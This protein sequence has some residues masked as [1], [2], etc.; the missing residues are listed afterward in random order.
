MHTHAPQDLSLAQASQVKLGKIPGICLPSK[1]KR[2]KKKERVLSLDELSAGHVCAEPLVVSDR[3]SS[4]V[5][6]E[7][8]LMS[9]PCERR[10]N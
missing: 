6:L 10:E 9:N 1:T 7:S 3:L 4:H 8:R 5:F 2:P